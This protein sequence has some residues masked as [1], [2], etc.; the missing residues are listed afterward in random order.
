MNNYPIFIPY[1][2]SDLWGF[3]NPE[4][5]VLIKCEY[6][7]VMC[8]WG[9]T[10]IVKK[11]G[12]YGAINMEGKLYVPCK[13]PK[14]LTAVYREI[15]FSPATFFIEN[16][17]D[18]LDEDDFRC[19]PEQGTV[20][21]YCGVDF[22]FKDGMYQFIDQKISS[23]HYEIVFPYYFNNLLWVKKHN[24]Y[25][26]ITTDGK[27]VIPFMYDAVDFYDEDF[28]EY[29]FVELDGKW[30]VINWKNVQYWED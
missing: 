27:Q 14:Y 20:S 12:L 29:T 21:Q 16:D 25:G 6:D 11:N 5:E 13:Y 8:F 18:G 2:K 23:E 15:F 26:V 7:E 17:E 3:S 1:Q 30:G 4:K 9:D 28:P 22:I 24:K 19:S 10:A